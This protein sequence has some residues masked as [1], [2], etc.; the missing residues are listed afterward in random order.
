MLAAHHPTYRVMTCVFCLVVVRMLSS[1]VD[2]QDS[3]GRAVWATE[4]PLFKKMSILGVSQNMLS[5]I[6]GNRM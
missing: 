4:T 3:L 2:F 1:Y 6:C 5:L